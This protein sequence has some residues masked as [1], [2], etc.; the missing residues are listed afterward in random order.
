M[1]PQSAVRHLESLV[2]RLDAKLSSFK[3][4][5][6]SQEHNALKWLLDHARQQAA[7]A[8]KVSTSSA[9]TATPA[10]RIDLP[11]PP[12]A[13][14]VPARSTTTPPPAAAPVVAIAPKPKARPSIKLDL[15]SV[16]RDR[17]EDPGLTLCLDFGTAKSKACAAEH[18]AGSEATDYQLTELGLGVEDGDDDAVYP[19]NSS[20]WIDDDGKMWFGSEAIRRS[21]SYKGSKERTRLDSLKHWITIATNDSEVTEL[22]LSD[23]DNPTREV[24]T[25][26]DAVTMYL[27][28]ITDLSTS[29]IQRKRKARYVSRR[30]TLPCWPEEH[31]EWSLPYLASRICRAQV[32][33]DS[34]HG[35]WKSGIPVAKAADALFAVTAHDGALGYL[36][37]RNKNS[38]QRQSR[39]WGGVLEPIAAGSSRLWS[40]RNF[41]ELALTLDVGAGTTDLALSFVVQNRHPKIGVI[42][43]RAIPVAPAARALPIAG[44]YLDQG[45]LELLL[46]RAG[47]SLGTDAYLRAAGRLRLFGAR[48]L[49]EQLFRTGTVATRVGD[50]VIQI[51]KSQFLASSAAREFEQ[52]IRHSMTDFVGNLHPTWKPNIERITLVAT[53]GSSRLPFIE[54]LHGSTLSVLGGTSKLSAAPALPEEL[55]EY[56]DRFQD[57]YPQMA[58]AIGGCCPTL[59]DEQ[60]TIVDWQG[61]AATPGPLTRYATKGV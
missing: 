13:T 18:S 23:Q 15:T 7:A 38:D 25:V 44:D 27:A 28:Y 12:K 4:L 50:K 53:G 56:S 14:A 21:A 59:M 10:A 1:T 45:L 36:L 29:A 30:F 24:L 26:D 54:T 3:G 35:Q 40:E 37:D 57:A 61:G 58:V 31:R 55:E 6:S 51:S 48:R 39:F 8:E 17:V 43:H 41:R 34:F 49:K 9:P 11:L 52:R 20:V 60:H 47:L 2:D 32:L 16:N 42:G 46:S 5:V 22:E 19:V 33:A